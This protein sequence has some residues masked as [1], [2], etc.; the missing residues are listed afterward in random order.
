MMRKAKRTILIAM[1][2]CVVT[3]PV[4][5][6]GTPRS[7]GNLKHP[8]AFELLDKYAAGQEKM[9]S[10][11]AKVETSRE[12]FSSGTRSDKPRRFRMYAE[13][14]V[15]FDGQRACFRKASWGQ[16]SKDDYYE[17]DKPYYLSALWDGTTFIHY[18]PQ[19]EG[20]NFLI[21]K[22]P[23]GKGDA[24]KTYENML[25]GDHAAKFLLGYFYPWSARIDALLREAD[26]I[27]VR[28]EMA[29]VGDGTCYVID[30]AKNKGKYTVWIDPEHGYHIARIEIERRQRDIP[31]LRLFSCVLKNVRFKQFDNVW[32]P[33]EA[34]LKDR[35]VYPTGQYT[36]DTYRIKMKEIVLNCDHDR[37]GSFL[38]DDIKDGS[39]VLFINGVHVRDHVWR[40]G[41]VLDKAGKVVLDCTARKASRSRGHGRG[42]APAV[43]VSLST[44]STQT[45]RLTRFSRSSSRKKET[46][47]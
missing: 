27:S 36:N 30:A 12:G 37:I 9:R 25:K 31:A 39:K 34:D 26:T 42:G 19:R 46:L 13:A 21:I 29:K 24:A 7:K 35:F 14:D 41:K 33:V 5:S 15:R 10:F 43:S 28:P 2:I 4:C 8:A 23:K 18:R 38:P 20:W 1:L 40:D 16:I 22:Q 32:V 45:C 47:Q 6:A 17:K 11:T 3:V 44:S